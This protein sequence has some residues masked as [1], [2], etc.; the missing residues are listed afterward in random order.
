M[1]EYKIGISVIGSGLI[2]DKTIHRIAKSLVA[3]ANT[4]NNEEGMIV[5]GISDSDDAYR[6]WRNC[7]KE[8]ATIV[9]QHYVVGIEKETE[10]LGV[11]VDK[12]VSLLREKLSKEHISEPLKSFVLGN[13]A[14]YDYY[15][16]KLVVIKSKHFEEDSTYDGRIYRREG[17]ESVPVK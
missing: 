2:K 7:Y 4:P 10:S 13:F 6:D 3:M 14:Q 5:I 9:K 16:K 12:Y 17:N 8:A 1:F 15:D 11:N